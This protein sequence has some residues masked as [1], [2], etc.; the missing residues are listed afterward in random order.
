MVD[1]SPSAPRTVTCISGW[2]TA[3]R[4]GDP[5]NHAQNPAALLGKML[6]IDPETGSPLTY[7]VPDINP[8]TQTKGYRAEIWAARP[9]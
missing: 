4:G 3:A 7:T 1:S 9:A 2:A 6:R 5:Q 8:F